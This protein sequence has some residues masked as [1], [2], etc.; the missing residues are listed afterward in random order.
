MNGVNLAVADFPWSVS[1]PC[2]PLTFLKRWAHWWVPELGRQLI[3]SLWKLNFSVGQTALAVFCNPLSKS[4]MHE[5]SWFAGK[6]SLC[7]G[8]EN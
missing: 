6:V 5:I 1:C 7:L 8:G 2:C 3:P 4:V